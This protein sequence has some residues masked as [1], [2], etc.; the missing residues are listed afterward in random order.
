MS[1]IKSVKGIL[2]I[3][4]ALSWLGFCGAGYIYWDKTKKEIDNKDTQVAQLQMDL[5]NIGQLVSAYSLAAD[6]KMGKQIQETDFSEV[7][8]PIGATTGMLLTLDDVVGKYYKVD[9]TAGTL[10]SPDMVYDDPITDDLRLVDVIL[11]NIPVGLKAGNYVDVRISL[12]LGEDFIALAHKKVHSVNAGVLKLVLSSKDIHTYNSMLIDSL[13][14]SGTSLYA[15]EYLQ[16]GAQ[17]PADSFYPVAT[18]ILSVAQSDPNLLEA[19]KADMLQRRATYDK[20]MEGIVT[21]KDQDDL[22]RILVRGRD[23]YTSL[24]DSAERAFTQEENKRLTEE[25][26]AGKAKK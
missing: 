26:R 16:G 6:V 2:T 8:V 19:I 3:V 5:D 4:L 9:I 25:A 1:F 10:I 21:Y 15:V 20:S 14:Y 18:N 13:V 22:E 24:L 7:L 17:R 23:K 12:P 11:N